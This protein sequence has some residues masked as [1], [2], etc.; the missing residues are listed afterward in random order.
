VSCNASVPDSGN[1]GE[2][3]GSMKGEKLYT[4][5][6]AKK[7]VAQPVEPGTAKEAYK[8]VQ[9]EVAEVRNQKKYPLT[10][11]VDFRDQDGAMAHLGSFSLYPADNPGK[12]IVATQGKLKDGGAI[13]LSLVPPE[14]VPPGDEVRVTV[15]R[16]TFLKG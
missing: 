4:L 6:L 10:F 1:K 15:K 5:D 3:N 14:N 9:I 7:S 13:V 12:F 11:Q 16:F 8:F 2:S